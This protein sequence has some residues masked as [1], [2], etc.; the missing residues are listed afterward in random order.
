MNVDLVMN[1]APPTLEVTPTTFTFAATQIETSTAPQTFTMQNIG[2]DTLVVNPSDITIVGANA[3]QFALTTIENPDTLA[4][5]ETATFTVVFSPTT[6]GEKTATINVNSTGSKTVAIS[7]NAI[8][9]TITEFP[10]YE[11]FDGEE[12]STI[13]LVKPRCL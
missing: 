8:D 10:Y 2:G 5:G 6:V 7:G 13:R 11:T 3:D 4:T 12:L 1:V 9:L